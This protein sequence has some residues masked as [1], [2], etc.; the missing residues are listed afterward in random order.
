MLGGFLLASPWPTP[1]PDDLRDVTVFVEVDEVGS[2]SNSCGLTGILV[3]LSIE[4]DV[5]VI[6]EYQQAISRIPNMK[7][8]MTTMTK[9]R[10]GERREK[11]SLLEE[12]HAFF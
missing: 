2:G 7:K 9:N 12:S 8:E 3:D 5:N 10:W 6:F 4:V 11:K 1:P